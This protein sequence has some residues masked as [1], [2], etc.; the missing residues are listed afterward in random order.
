L[1]INPISTVNGNIVIDINIPIVNDVELTFSYLG[2]SI[3]KNIDTNNLERRN[4]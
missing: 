1:T 4:I 2:K 3:V